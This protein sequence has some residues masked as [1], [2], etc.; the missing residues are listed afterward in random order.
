MAGSR[1]AKVRRDHLSAS[2]SQRVLLFGSRLASRRHNAARALNSREPVIDASLP[3]STTMP[4]K[5]ET[6]L[7]TLIYLKRTCANSAAAADIFYLGV[8]SRI[9]LGQQIAGLARLRRRRRRRCHRRRRCGGGL[10]PTG[11]RGGSVVTSETIARLRD[12]LTFRGLSDRRLAKCKKRDQERD[13][14][15]CNSPKRFGYHTGRS[16]YSR[17]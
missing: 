14:F 6:R 2:A 1:A 8:Q 9:F 5:P 16:G 15:H 10:D 7:T 3:E 12:R 13:G 4:S 17:C 11:W